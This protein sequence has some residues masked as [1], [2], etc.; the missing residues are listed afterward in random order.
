MYTELIFA[1]ELKQDIPESVIATLKYMMGQ[2]DLPEKLAFEEGFFSS[3]SFS[4][5]LDRAQNT[6]YNNGDNWILS[7]RG[8]YKTR[9]NDGFIDLFLKW[10]KPYISRGSGLKDIYAITIYEHNREI[11]IHSLE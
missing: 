8:N 9:E 10:I 6:L 1:A 5:P 2:G 11:N 4:F 3:A 7:H